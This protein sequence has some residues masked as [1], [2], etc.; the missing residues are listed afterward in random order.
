MSIYERFGVRPL[1]NASGYVT[2]M[3]GSLM[4]PEVVEA[5]AE[6]SRSYVSMAELERAASEVIARHTGSEAGYVTSGAAAGLTLAAAACLA[7]DDPD[8]M[9]R[10][11]DTTGMPDEIIIPGPH[12]D[13]YDRCLRSAGAKIVIA[14]T[15]E[16]CSL[17]DIRSAISEDSVAIALFS[18]HEHRDLPPG[19]VIDI[20]HQYDLPVIID[21]AI[22]LPP[23]ENLRRFIDLG[24]DLVIYSAGKAMYGPQTAGFVAGKQRFIDSIARQHQDLAAYDGRWD[25]SNPLGSPGH[26]IGRGMKAGKEE[27]VGALVAL[28]MFAS[29]DHAAELAAQHDGATLVADRLEGRPGISLEVGHHQTPGVFVRAGVDP[30][31]VGKTAMEIA[32]ALLATEPRVAVAAGMFGDVDHFRIGFAALKPGEAEII[33]DKLDDVL[34]RV[35]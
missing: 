14:G 30:K 1:I 21:A 25:L 22:A 27:I 12:R 10:L 18:E 28:E 4:L 7:G 32:D 11:P 15:L 17:D 26:G 23:P 8:R 35:D 9:N 13:S 6:A 24:A 34:G 16:S 19:D 31:I 2:R 20:A 3:S 33:A 5:M 29:R